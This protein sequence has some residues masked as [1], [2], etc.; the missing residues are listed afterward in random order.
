MAN[1]D[2]QGAVKELTQAVEFLKATGATKV[3]RGLRQRS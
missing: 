3:R 1:L 2:W